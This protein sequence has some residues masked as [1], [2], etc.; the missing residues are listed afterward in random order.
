EQTLNAALHLLPGTK[1]VVVVGGRGK[2]DIAW[3][4]VA[5]LSFHNYESKLEF[6]Y[7]TNLTMPT[8][9]ERLQHLPTNTIVYHTAITED[10]AGNRFIDATQSVPLVARSANAPVFVMDDVDLNGGTVGGYLVNWADDGRVAAEMAVRVLNGER[11]RDIPVVTSRSA[12]MFDWRA[13]KRWGLKQS[14]LPPGSIVLHREPSFW[15]LYKQYVLIGIVVLLAQTAAILGLLW[16]R[17]RRARAERELKESEGRFRTVADTAP[18]LIW[19][20]GTDRLLTYFN[21]PWLRFTGRSMQQELGN[22]WTDA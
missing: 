16:Q 5:E 21:K 2:F 9:L 20:S 11:T 7:L 4:A 19:M 6:T 15:D 1:H 12:Y 13:L 14:E 8:L 17:R 10:A 18:V 3:E 22:G